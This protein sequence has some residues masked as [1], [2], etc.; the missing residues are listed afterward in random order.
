VIAR[1]CDAIKSCERTYATDRQQV[2]R[3]KVRFANGILEEE[4]KKNRGR[5]SSWDFHENFRILSSIAQTKR[6]PPTEGDNY[7][8]SNIKNSQVTSEQSELWLWLRYKIHISVIDRTVGTY[9][10]T[11]PPDRRLTQ[12][13]F[14]SFSQSV[15][16]QQLRFVSY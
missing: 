10:M 5:G 6:S 7:F 9:R 2:V 14:V 11:H 8:T 13:F 1:S 16:T 12:I 3:I 4:P 15:L